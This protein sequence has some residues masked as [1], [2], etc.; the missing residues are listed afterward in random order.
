MAIKTI[1][2]STQQNVN[3]KKAKIENSKVKQKLIPGKEQTAISCTA[4][5]V[6]YWVELFWKS[7]K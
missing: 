7:G 2:I 4:C 5:G 3:I 1:E 6:D